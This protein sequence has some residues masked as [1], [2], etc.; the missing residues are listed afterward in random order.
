VRKSAFTVPSLARASSW[1]I[2]VE[3]GTAS[4]SSRRTAA[5]TFVIAW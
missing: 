2:S 3:K 1:S 5:G 4:A